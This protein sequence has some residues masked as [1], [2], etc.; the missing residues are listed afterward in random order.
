MHLLW[1]FSFRSGSL[2][3]CLGWTFLACLGTDYNDNDEVVNRHLARG[4]A[5]ASSWGEY[6]EEEES[7]PAHF[8][9]VRLH[10]FRSCRRQFIDHSTVVKD[11]MAGGKV[12]LVVLVVGKKTQASM[13]GT[14]KWSWIEWL[15]LAAVDT[16]SPPPFL[17]PQIWICSWMVHWRGDSGED[18][19]LLGF[20]TVRNWP[21]N[22][23][24]RYQ[25]S[26]FQH[27]LEHVRLD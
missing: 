12:V 11:E 19:F 23:P 15:P 16:S 7:I 8:V 21:L 10:G 27:L 22:H 1:L 20:F 25:G 2:G 3:C 5:Q 14:I 17:P 26:P 13:R 6:E 9:V 4:E 24:R 18:N